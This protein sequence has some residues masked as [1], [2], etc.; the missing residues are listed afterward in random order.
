MHF[1][2][3][4]KP[5]RFHLHMGLAPTVIWY[6]LVPQMCHLHCLLSTPE[7][8]SVRPGNQSVTIC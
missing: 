6:I 4:E 5:I 7:V 1:I 2:S 3:A 8:V